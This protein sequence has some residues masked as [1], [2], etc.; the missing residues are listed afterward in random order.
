MRAC[1]QILCSHPVT[2]QTFKNK[3]SFFIGSRLRLKLRE[4]MKNE[5]LFL[6]V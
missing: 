1:A 5:V 3:T 6:K 4:P 2:G